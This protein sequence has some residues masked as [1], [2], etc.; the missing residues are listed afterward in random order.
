M[1]SPI[2][3]TQII[4]SSTSPSSTSNTLGLT[5]GSQSVAAASS[6]VTLGT[7]GEIEFSSNVTI[8]CSLPQETA[9]SVVSLAYSTGG[10]V[11]Y[12]STYKDS[13]YVVIRIPTTSYQRVLVEVEGMGNATSVISSSNDVSVQYTDLN[14]SLRSLVTE[15]GAL[16]RLLNQS[17][18]INTTLAIE[19]QLQGVDQQINE[20]QSEILQTNTLVDFA[21]VDVNI[22]K[23]S[24]PTPLTMT[25][26][27]TPIN[28]TAPLSVTF[29]AVVKGGAQP[30]IVNYNFGDGTSSQG[31]VLIHTYNAAGTYKVT[32]TVTDQNGTVA[33]A[34][35]T[36]R[37]AAPPG[38]VGLADFTGTIASLF[39]S[40]VEGIAEV[41]AVVLPLAAVGAMVIIPMRRRSRSQK[42]V[43]QD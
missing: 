16:L 28:G 5:K 15:Q 23:S 19:G 8:S 18:S 24:P 4:Q 11:A 2:D 33:K 27:A 29:N 17:T 32:V 42:A 9:A 34:A 39:I 30:Y 10:Y 12:Q 3:G 31:Q 21:T 37:V 20:V 43:K 26:T 13:A 25:L 41:G 1:R 6:N 40:V 38:R 14:A 36:I 35:S 22:V 7:N